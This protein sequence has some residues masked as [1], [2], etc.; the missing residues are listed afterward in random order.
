LDLSKRAKKQQLILSHFIEQ[1]EPIEKQKL[2]ALLKITDSTIKTLVDKQLIETEKAEVY[3]NPYNDRMITRTE[4]LPLTPEQRT[5]I[6][7]IN[8]KIA[9]EEHDV[10]LL[11]GVTGSG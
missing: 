3:R 1:P 7:P 4:A 2:K 8:D 6:K 5:A 11:H 10:F 9:E